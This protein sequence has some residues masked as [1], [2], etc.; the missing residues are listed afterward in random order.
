MV[1]I[2]EKKIIYYDSLD[3]YGK[4][5]ERYLTGMNKWLHDEAK[6]LN[7]DIGEWITIYAPNVP[8]QYDST[9]CGVYVLAIAD[10]LASDLPLNNFSHLDVNEFRKKICLDILNIIH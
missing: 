7:I 10:L 6:K 3:N 9:S 2:E 1:Y 4:F 8:R 5:A